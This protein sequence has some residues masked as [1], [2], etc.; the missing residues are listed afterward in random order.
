M[1]CSKPE[2]FISF[3]FAT[4]YQF[5]SLF[6]ITFCAYFNC[7]L[8]HFI[9]TMI[10][11]FSV[12]IISVNKRRGDHHHIHRQSEEEVMLA[13]EILVEAALVSYELRPFYLE[14]STPTEDCWPAETISVF[15]SS[16]QDRYWSVS[17]PLKIEVNCAIVCLKACRP[18]SDSGINVWLSVN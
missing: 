6:Y 18:G 8:F 4:V 2:R 17:I 5:T 3:A 16:M 7:F 13:L 12:Q 9:V 1:K 11:H 15:C 10:N 14:L